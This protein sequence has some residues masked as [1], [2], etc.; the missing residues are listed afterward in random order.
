MLLASVVPSFV[1]LEHQDL[2]PVPRFRPLRPMVVH[3]SICELFHAFKHQGS[4][5]SPESDGFNDIV[6]A[7][8]QPN[9]DLMVAV[10]SDPNLGNEAG[11][12]TVR[13]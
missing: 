11:G 8:V 10:L 1:T 7:P 12:D 9:T 4:C 13:S 3:N 2:V 5:L 6:S